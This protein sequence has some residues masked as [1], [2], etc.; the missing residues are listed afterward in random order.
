MPY[1]FGSFSDLEND[2][3]FVLA[4]NGFPSFVG[5]RNSNW[6]FYGQDDWRVNRKLTLNLGL[7]YDFNTVWREGQ[8]RMQNFDVATQS[9][10]P[11]TQAPYTTP[12]DEFAPRIG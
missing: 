9:F 5:V 8:N 3:P 7:R 1:F 4:K 6:D 11:S 2:N 12:K 10:L